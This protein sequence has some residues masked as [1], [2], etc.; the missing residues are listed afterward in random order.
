MAKRSKIVNSKCFR[1]KISLARPGSLK[2]NN[3]HD[4]TVEQNYARNATEAE[5]SNVEM[6][7]I[8]KA[9][10]KENVKRAWCI[11]T[12]IQTKGEAV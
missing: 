3:H 7:A 11:Q 1:K 12:I 10:I 9:L 6:V 8:S 5:C 2:C 4:S